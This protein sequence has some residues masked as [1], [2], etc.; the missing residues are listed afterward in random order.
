MKISKPIRLF[1]GENYSEKPPLVAKAIQKAAQETIEIIN[2]Y[3]GSIYQDAVKLIAK[4]LKVKEEQ[5]VFGHG[6]E[7][8]I[9]LTSMAFLGKGKVGGMFQPSFFV[10]ANNLKRGQFLDYPCSYNQKVDLNRFI[11][12]LQ[13]IDVFFLASPNTAT[14]N[15]LLT[16]AEIEKV[17][18]SY[19]GLLVVDE[20]YFGIGNQTV[21]D[22]VKK[23]DNLLIYRGLTKVMGLGSLR[24]G[25]AIGQKKIIDQLKYHFTEIE[26][27]PVNTFSLKVFLA[28]FP[29]FKS[30]V[31]NTNN[32][33]DQ[34]LDY[35]KKQF[36]Q[37]KFIKNVTTFHFMDIRRYKVANYKVQNY[38]NQKGYIFSQ[39]K[40]E[41]NKGINFPE[42]IMLTP[43]PKQ[44]WPDFAR[45][46]KQALR[47]K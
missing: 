6:I 35:M 5:I 31:Q 42:L 14:G 17:L 28:A 19:K 43:P 34:F 27:D 4:T 45:T 33:F 24:L 29:Y 11:R 41:N 15:Y 16:R 39:E 12:F 2:L 21:I 26:L 40:L 18:K 8:L 3:P 32:F 20:C 9:H 7:G 46:L 37:D 36:P 1:W 44:L 10:F 23:Y 47:Q 25:F 38:M 13:K 30:L 22:L